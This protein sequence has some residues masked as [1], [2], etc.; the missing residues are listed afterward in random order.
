MHVCEQSG[1]DKNSKINGLHFVCCLCKKKTF[2]ECAYNEFV[3]AKSILT[4]MKVID[5]DRN[6]ATKTKFNENETVFDAVFGSDSHFNF[7]CHRCKEENMLNVL[8]KKLSDGLTAIQ[9]LTEANVSMKKATEL[10]IGSKNEEIEILKQNIRD[11]QQQMSEKIKL[12]NELTEA[13]EHPNNVTEDGVQS[14]PLADVLSKRLINCMSS[15]LENELEKMYTKVSHECN[16]IKDQCAKLVN[17]FDNKTN[18]ITKQ[19]PF[20]R[21]NNRN[22]SFT[23]STEMNSR[24]NQI[25]PS[26][27]IH[28]GGALNTAA[29]IAND[30]IEADHD[31]K[32]ENQA[33]SVFNAK[34][35]PTQTGNTP[36]TEIHSI[37][38]SQFKLNITV[39]DI[40]EHILHNIQNVNQDDVT[41]ERLDKRNSDFISFKISTAKSELY[42]KMM[43]IWSPHYT[44]RKFVTNT[45]SSPY[46]NTKTPMNTFRKF[47]TYE[48][49]SHGNTRSSQYTPKRQTQNKKQGHIN[50]GKSNSNNKYKRGT[51]NKSDGQ[52]QNVDIEQDRT[53]QKQQQQQ[54]QPTNYIQRQQAVHQ[55][56]QQMIQ[57]Q[58]Q[59]MIQQQQALQHPQQMVTLPYHT[60]APATAQTGFLGG[61][62]IHHPHQM[63]QT[64]QQHQILPPIHYAQQQQIQQHAPATFY[65]PIQ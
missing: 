56:S 50:N 57:Q 51:Y 55:Q 62:I 22:V 34:L 38:V 24:G 44:A 4:A 53:T 17:E 37:H 19:N 63:N 12:I 41:V 43:S 1:C 65:V 58:A 64:Q 36:T 21:K 20:S 60:N 8:K 13:S 54:Q 14:M 42:E 48:T 30:Q 29:K 39:D 46:S 7:I 47:T 27:S 61:H 49:P 16:S 52:T 2:A 9:N 26:S 40:M 31:K 45:Y 5:I 35:I 3:E 32:N 6:D 28:F 25:M 10:E 33:P 23:A 11:L 15:V 18:E 59:P